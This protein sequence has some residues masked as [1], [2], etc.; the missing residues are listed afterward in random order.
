VP[1]TTRLHFRDGQHVVLD[2]AVDQVANEIRGGGPI[3]LTTIEGTLIFVNWSNVL[4]IEERPQERGGPP[5]FR[6]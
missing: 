1:G 6:T 4:Y 2:A 5:P 3:R